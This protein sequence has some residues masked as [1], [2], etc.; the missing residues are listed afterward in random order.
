MNASN[1]PKTI[2]IGGGIVGLCCAYYLK[3]QGREVIIIEKNS[4]EN[5]SACSY[6]NAGLLVPSHFIP[7]A[8]PGV[9]AQGIK[10]MFNARS[11]LYVH[12]RLDRKL[13]AW[14]WNFHKSAT[15]QHVQQSAPLLRD[16]NQL[17]KSLYR[18]MIAEENL[19]VS[20]S[21]KGLLM[22]CKTEK[23]LEEERKTAEQANNIGIEARMLNV[24]ELHELEPQLAIDA[25]GASYYPG[26][27]HFT[28]QRMMKALRNYLLENGVDI[29][30]HTTVQDFQ[31]SGNQLKSILT[32][33]KEH[34]QADE[35]ILA[36][37]SWTGKLAQKLS[38]TIPVQAGKGYSFE[39]DN[40]VLPLTIPSILTEAKIA[41]TPMEGEVRF[42]GTMELG[43][44]TATINHKRLN[45]IKQSIP[46]YY[47]EVTIEK[48]DSIKPWSGLR[49]CSPDGLPYIGRSK[50]ISNL[51]VASGHAMMGMS[52]GAVTGKLVSEIALRQTPSLPLDLLKVDRFGK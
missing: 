48:L 49:P 45:T 37:G 34:I 6:G 16:L 46:H 7:L 42:A 32:D 12:P 43:T 8:A 18:E 23:Y 27:A 41:I 17:S 33:K 35:V 47:P 20:L 5:T 50:H 22:V 51:I 39:T 15:T 44:F 21:E 40:S 38:L 11:P 2:I 10:W 4:A 14:M 36:T 30:Y 9:I 31:R 52:L 3:K 26:D 13:L 25:L 24:E 29:L 19:D 28:P 1:H